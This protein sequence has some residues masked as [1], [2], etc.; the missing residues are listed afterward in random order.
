MLRII[1]C[2]QLLEFLADFLGTGDEPSFVGVDAEAVQLQVQL[3]ECGR[4]KVL[5]VPHM[6]DPCPGCHRRRHQP[7]SVAR[8][9]DAFEPVA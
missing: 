5:P 7:R 2:Q 9:L 6:P 3:K 1:R 4:P 8:Q